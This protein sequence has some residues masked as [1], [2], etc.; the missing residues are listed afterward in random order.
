VAV[1]LRNHLPGPVTLYYQL[2]YRSTPSSFC[3]P[4]AAFNTSNVL[5]LTWP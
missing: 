3:D 4:A 5:S 2:W 1:A